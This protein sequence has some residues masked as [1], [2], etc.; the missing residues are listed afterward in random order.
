MYMLF[1]Q[2]VS[3]KFE[4]YFATDWIAWNFQDVEK[5]G[6]KKNEAKNYHQRVL[7][8]PVGGID[9]LQDDKGNNNI[10]ATTLSNC[11]TYLT[12]C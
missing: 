11:Y 9:K 1:K 6:E 5:I 7:L 10:H 2:F 4:T 12:I 3:Y 8:L